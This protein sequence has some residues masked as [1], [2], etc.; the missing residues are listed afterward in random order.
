MGEFCGFV[1]GNRVKEWGFKFHVSN[2]S[3]RTFVNSTSFMKYSSKEIL[4]KVEKF[5]FK[6]D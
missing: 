3:F 6:F 4:L 5:V 2:I 1:E